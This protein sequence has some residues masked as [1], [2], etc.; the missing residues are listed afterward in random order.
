MKIFIDNFITHSAEIEQVLEGMSETDEVLKLKQ[1][2]QHLKQKLVQ[3]KVEQEVS[4]DPG[5]TTEV[6]FKNVNYSLL[7]K[8]YEPSVLRDMK[9]NDR[10]SICLGLV[11]WCNKNNMT[12]LEHWLNVVANNGNQ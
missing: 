11:N 7:C 12:P 2:V 9:V 3:A 6:E 5:R 1:L 4:E 10:Y 8:G